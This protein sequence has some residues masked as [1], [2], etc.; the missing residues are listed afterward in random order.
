MDHSAKKE[1]YSEQIMFCI[2]SC[3]IG[4]CVGAA[5]P[6]W[7]MIGSIVTEVSYD[8]LE[9][10][11]SGCTMAN[12]TVTTVQMSTEQWLMTTVADETG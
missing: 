3:L 2:Q 7:I 8:Q 9:L 11:T 12:C 10:Y 6:L 5:L 1:H 4:F